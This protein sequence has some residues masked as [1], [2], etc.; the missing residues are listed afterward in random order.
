[1]DEYY[2]TGGLDVDNSDQMKEYRLRQKLFLSIGIPI[3]AIGFGLI[4]GGIFAAVF[5]RGGFMHFIGLFIGGLFTLITGI[6]MTVNGGSIS[7]TIKH[8]YKLNKIKQQE[9]DLGV[10]ICRRCGA[11]NEPN[12]VKCKK[13]RRQ[14]NPYGG[15]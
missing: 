6:V 4:V 8:A 10:K 3:T 2:W 14:I 11:L 7:L 13:C 5:Y 1:M 12:A 15:N 9:S